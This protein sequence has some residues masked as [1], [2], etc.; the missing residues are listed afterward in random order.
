MAD[1]S[2]IVG[3]TMLIKG[4]LEGDEDL[5]VQGR[6]EGSLSLTKTL[7]IEP[8]GVVKADVSV[9]NAV[10]SGVMVGNL[11]ASD[12]LEITDTG[13]MV[14]D[15]RAPRVIIVEGASV[16]GKV[17]MGDLEMP[18]PSSDRKPVYTPKP[19]ARPSAPAAK[20]KPV[21]KTPAKKAALPPPPPKAKKAAP[22][23]KAAAKPSKKKKVVV[24][25][26]RR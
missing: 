1:T 20:P 15:I 17:D 18:R 12:S 24:K 7:I 11:T 4:N 5:T 14:G 2:T 3:Q 23:P 22:P 21:V 6:I 25:K 16:R 19:M 8:N 10:I 9:A 13:R 26:K